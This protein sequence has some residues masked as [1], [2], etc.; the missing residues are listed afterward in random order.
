MTAPNI[1]FITRQPVAIVN[2]I[3]ACLTLA[4][5]YGVQV[6]SSQQTQ[7][8]LVIGLGIVLV[9]GSAIQQSLVTPVAAPHLPAGTQVVVIPAVA[10]ATFTVTF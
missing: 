4:V 2:F 7:I 8:L 6:S 10:P 1:S 3:K 5:M 9:G